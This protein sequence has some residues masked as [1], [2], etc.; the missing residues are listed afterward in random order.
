MMQE[1][2]SAVANSEIVVN[3]N[4]LTSRSYMATDSEAVTAPKQDKC[5][6]IN[7]FLM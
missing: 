5:Y 4:K 7:K 6:N 1:K 2:E 3:R